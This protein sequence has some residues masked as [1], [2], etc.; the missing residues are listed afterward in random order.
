MIGKIFAYALLVSIVFSCE[1]KKEE[2]PAPSEPAVTGDTVVLKANKGFETLAIMASTSAGGGVGSGIYDTYQ[3]VDMMMLPDGKT[4]HFAGLSGMN[5]QQDK[6]YSLERK[7]IDVSTKEILSPSTSSI[8]YE[9]FK[10]G[11]PPT[12][13]SWLNVGY[14][15]QP[16]TNKLFKGEISV[17]NFGIVTAKILGDFSY[18]RSNTFA[19]DPRISVHGEVMESVGSDLTQRLDGKYDNR[20]FF[21]YSDANKAI[22]TNAIYRTIA[23]P[24]D[25]IVSGAIETAT[26]QATKIL[27]FGVSKRQLYV[28]EAPCIPF[29]G[30]SVLTFIDSM[31]LPSGWN[32]ASIRTRMADDKSGFAISAGKQEADMGLRV[33][34][35]V[36]NL[37]NKKFTK[38]ITDLKI[39]GYSTSKINCDMDG[40]GNIYFDNYGD[41]FR[42]DS[43]ISIYKASANAITVVG[44]D[45]LIKSGSI[46][47]VRFLQGKVYAAVEY[48]WSLG[49]V[50][51][52]RIAIIKQD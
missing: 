17:S 21:T 48:K 8:P 50:K 45:N 25:Q 34:S 22:Y 10:G 30:N 15:Y 9:F 37:A 5:T 11:V 29:P 27:F 51:K 3:M 39:P 13:G 42:S 4:L 46:T 47:K 52:Y 49:T 20:L 26:A 2:V 1:P 14:G 24:L 12:D 41:N 18:S 43:T 16:G 40:E 23:D 36:Y 33:M 38:N 28:G 44:Q 31:P 6:L 35:A 32:G 19:S 7:A